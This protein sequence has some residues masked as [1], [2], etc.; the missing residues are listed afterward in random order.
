M[1]YLS[2]SINLTPIEAPRE[3]PTG[4][5]DTGQK[6]I[7]LSI[8]FLFI[9]GIV[10]AIILLIYSGIQWILSGGNKEVIASARSRITFT[11]IGLVIM[12]LSFFIVNSIAGFFN[13]SFLR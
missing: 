10:F 4:G 8:T 6:V 2:L 13:I 5:I 9:I 3:V 11:V 12:F 7:Q 1:K